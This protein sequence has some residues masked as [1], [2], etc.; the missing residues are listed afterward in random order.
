VSKPALRGGA[1]VTL[2][3][4]LSGYLMVSSNYSAGINFHQQKYFLFFNGLF[5]E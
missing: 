5:S 3:I 4:D 2:A 1:S